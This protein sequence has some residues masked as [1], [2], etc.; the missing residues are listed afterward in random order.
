M[1][2]QTH[3]ISSQEFSVKLTGKNRVVNLQ[4]LKIPFQLGSSHFPK[5][6]ETL[7]QILRAASLRLSLS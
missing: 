4:P 7:I 5:P 6:A 3:G 2:L 1:W